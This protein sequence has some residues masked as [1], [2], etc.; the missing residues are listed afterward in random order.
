VSRGRLSKVLGPPRRALNPALELRYT[1][2]GPSQCRTEGGVSRA[3]PPRKFR[4][5]A[6]SSSSPLRAIADLYVVAL[7][8]GDPEVTPRRKGVKPERPSR[9]RADQLR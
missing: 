5:A 1:V 4:P 2:T 6:A 3:A 7:S 8:S 9:R